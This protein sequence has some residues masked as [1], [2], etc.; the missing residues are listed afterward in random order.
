MTVNGGAN[1]KIVELPVGTY[2]ITEKT[3]WS[4]RYTPSYSN[5]GQA[6]LTATAPNG[7]ITCTNTSITDK[8]L[9]DYAVKSNTYQTGTP[10]T[11][12]NN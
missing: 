9:N 5:N 10:T 2:T 8:W 1:V 7:E 3:D 12:G 11:D 4:W 6:E